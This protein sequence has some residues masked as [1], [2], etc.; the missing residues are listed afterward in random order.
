MRAGYLEGQVGAAAPGGPYARL[1]AG[2]RP[3][4]QLGVFGFGQWSP[5]SST[6]G[7]GARWLFDQ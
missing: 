5:S 2:Y 7:V 6:A 1:E 3:R 4:E